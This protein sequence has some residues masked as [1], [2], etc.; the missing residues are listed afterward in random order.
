MA[1]NL[2]S[3]DK[4]VEMPYDITVLSI[5]YDNISNEYCIYGTAY[6]ITVLLAS[7][8]S[9]D[10]VYEVISDVRKNADMIGSKHD[11]YRFPKEK[12]VIRDRK[13]REKAKERKEMQL[14]ERM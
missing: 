11:L 1:I 14:K 12:T 4:R 7:Y 8:S 5:K 9:L 10:I 3:K 2:Q 6:G 13:T